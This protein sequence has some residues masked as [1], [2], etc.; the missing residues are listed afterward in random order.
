MERT[1]I[2]ADVTRSLRAEVGYLCPAPGCNSPY[3]TWHHFNPPYREGQSH[4]PTGI[5]ALCL[6]HH[7]EA[8]QGAFSLE[9][10]RG[11]KRILEK[12]PRP[13][14]AG[15]FNWRRDQLILE[16]GGNLLVRVQTLLQIGDRPIV[17][18]SNDENGH[19]LLNM[20]V[21][22]LDGRVLFQMRDNE[23]STA[24]LFDDLFCPPAA[25]S[26]VLRVRSRDIL[27]KLKFKSLTPPQLREHLVRRERRGME[28]SARHLE[29]NVVQRRR[30]RAP[31]HFLRHL[32]QSA[33]EM[34]ASAAARAADQAEHLYDR[35]RNG[36]DPSDYI[37]CEL[38]G[39][40]PFPVQVTMTPSR[41]VI[42]GGLTIGSSTMLG[43]M[44]AF[45]I[46]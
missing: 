42:G 5:V 1:S 41:T 30:E 40:L 31:E 25:D 23:W 2:P 44:T 35:I 26:I 14:P 12:G 32:E 10:L 39:R 4:E 46:G 13:M 27:L 7:K 29:Q 16:A 34:R 37:L 22:G 11:M 3:L 15:H 18:L 20:D 19:Q 21:Y 38:E 28:S 6:Q 45:Q 9:Q 43:G 24:E 17:W 33:S 36:Q 8:D